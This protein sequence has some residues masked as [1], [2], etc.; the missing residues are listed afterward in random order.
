MSGEQDSPAVP[1]KRVTSDFAIAS[2]ILGFIGGFVPVIA[3]PAIVCG[4]VARRQIRRSP[5][6][7]TGRRMAATGLGLGYFALVAWIALPSFNSSAIKGPGTRDLERAKQIMLGV[8]L[9]EGDNDEHTPPSLD[10]LFPTYL[11]D[12]TVFTSPLAPDDPGHGYDFLRP[13]AD[14][15]TFDARTT[16]LIRSHHAS[17]SGFRSYVYADGHGEFKRDPEA[18]SRW[19]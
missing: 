6:T 4:H 3:I 14:A 10:A 2:M 18:A 1:Q 5:A 7:L 11:P 9:Y 17:L 19:W 12:R 16:L 15:K 8:R 13:D